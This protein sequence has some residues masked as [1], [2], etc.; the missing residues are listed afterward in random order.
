MRPRKPLVITTYIETEEMID[1]VL[2]RNSKYV[3]ALW[4]SGLSTSEC[5]APE[6]IDSKEVRV[7]DCLDVWARVAR[8]EGDRQNRV[9]LVYASF[10]SHEAFSQFVVANAPPFLRQ[11]PYGPWYVDSGVV[12]LAV[13]EDA[14]W[15]RLNFDEAMEFLRQPLG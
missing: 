2:D 11:F 10:P 12:R 1:Q 13:W 5:I 8:R 3:E 7:E 14:R 15:I 6:T 9:E 4:A